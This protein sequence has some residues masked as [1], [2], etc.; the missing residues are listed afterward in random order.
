MKQLM[1][2]ICLTKKSISIFNNIFGRKKR[3]FLSFF[4]LITNFFYSLFQSTERFR[5]D[6]IDFILIE[7]EYL[8]CVKPFE[9]AIVYLWDAIV[10]QVQY[11]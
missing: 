8:Q 11:Q 1:M 9:C 3:I 7:S 2:S 4:F 5:F 10:I 6:D